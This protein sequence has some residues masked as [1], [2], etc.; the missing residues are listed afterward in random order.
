[1][2]Q[3]QQGIQETKFLLKELIEDPQ[4]LEMLAKL[5]KRHYDALIAENF[6]PD[7]ATKIVAHAAASPLIL[8]F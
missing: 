4:Y 8:D 7:Q 1:M 6:N 3:F 2:S 5:T